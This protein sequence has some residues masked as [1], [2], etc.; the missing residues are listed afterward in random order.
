LEPI[1]GVQG[2]L[3]PAESLK[4]PFATGTERLLRLKG[5]AAES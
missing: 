4:I 5:P 1:A 2:K 3:V